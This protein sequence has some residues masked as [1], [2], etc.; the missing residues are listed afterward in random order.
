MAQEYR[1]HKFVLDLPKE[2]PVPA[3]PKTATSKGVPVETA[4]S[5]TVQQVLTDLGFPLGKIDGIWGE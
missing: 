2:I 3:L 4:S 1:G 5:A